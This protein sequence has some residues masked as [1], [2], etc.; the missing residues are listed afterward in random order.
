VDGRVVIVLVHRPVVV[1]H[2]LVVSL[3][4]SHGLEAVGAVGKGPAGEAL[5]NNFVTA[6]DF[7]SGP[8]GGPGGRTGVTLDI[9][10]EKSIVFGIEG[11][12]RSF[13][14]TVCIQDRSVLFDGVS[15]LQILS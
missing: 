12:R 3:V 4:V 8:G 1:S 2:G 9:L 13:S 5:Q 15:Y 11:C 7:L 14:R 10:D 6:G